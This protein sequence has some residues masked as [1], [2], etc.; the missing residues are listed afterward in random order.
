[1]RL[2][3]RS[4][5]EKE[6]FLFFFLKLNRFQRSP[7]MIHKALLFSNDLDHALFCGFGILIS[8]YSLYVEIRKHKDSRYRA[9]CDFGEN[10][11]CSRV[12]ISR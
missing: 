7:T 4:H 5:Y 2:F 8:V 12:L 3:F 10:M 6:L 1:M 9:A 11:S